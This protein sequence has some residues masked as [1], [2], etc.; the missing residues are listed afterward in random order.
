M[1]ETA[2]GIP[3]QQITEA[4][5]SIVGAASVL[6]PVFNDAGV[7]ESGQALVRSTQENPV[8][9]S[10]VLAHTSSTLKAVGTAFSSPA[11]AESIVSNTG[12]MM[13]SGVKIMDSF[14]QMSPFANFMVRIGDGVGKFL[15]SIPFLNRWTK[16]IFDPLVKASSGY[17]KFIDERGGEIRQI[18]DAIRKGLIKE[19]V[20][21]KTGQIAQIVASGANLAPVASAAASGI[22]TYDTFRSGVDDVRQGAQDFF[23]PIGNF[24]KGLG[25]IFKKP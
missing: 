19:A 10:T 9:R 13:T 15:I 5:A 14:E 8:D 23:S 2:S 21:H 12:S 20:M 6:G 11:T 16:P 4:T 17:L 3:E 18:T 25:S 1:A 22:G 7:I 24:F